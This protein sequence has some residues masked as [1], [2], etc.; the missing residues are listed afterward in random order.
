M[1]AEDVQP[2]TDAGGETL[3][4]GLPV[5]QPPIAAAIDQTMEETLSAGLPTLDEA[6]SALPKAVQAQP[7]NPLV[8]A[9][10]KAEADDGFASLLA[11]QSAD[12]PEE[13][14][15][16]LATKELL[17]SLEGPKESRSSSSADPA[18]ARLNPLSQAI[19]Q[20]VQ[21]PQRPALVPGQPVQ[22]QQAGWSEAVVDRVMWL[23]SQNLKSAEI[24]LDPAELGRMEVRIDLTKDQAQVTFLSPH[25][26]VRDALE[27]QMP[28]V[29]EML[30]QQGMTLMDVNVSDQSLARG[31]Q[32]GGEGG[33][34][35]GGASAEAEE[36]LQVGV[37]EIASNRATGDRGLVGYYA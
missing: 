33:S 31:W 18:A 16:E 14:E 34:S 27:G 9:Q 8:D 26:G 29:R 21:Q 15:L 36:E 12:T 3:L 19:A 2:A 1:P 20:Q 25:A 10:A 4:S 11:G 35:R 32:G 13:P 23:S 17:E 37:S 5:A 30:T 28:R 22:M 24:Q 6:S 7:Q